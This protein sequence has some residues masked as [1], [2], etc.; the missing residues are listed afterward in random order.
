MKK[1]LTIGSP[2]L[3]AILLLGA[4]AC[5]PAAQ[6]D[7]PVQNPATQNPAA[8]PDTPVQG[9]A[10]QE[11]VAQPNTPAPPQPG[12]VETPAPIDGVE[13]VVSGDD[14]PQYT[15]EIVS[16][17]PSGCIKFGG[18]AVSRVDNTIHVTVNNLRPTSPAP[19]TMIYGTF[20]GQVDLGSGFIP[21]ESYTVVVN[22]KTTNTFIA[23]SPEGEKMTQTQSPIEKT[24]VMASQTEPFEYTLQVVSRL[25]MGSSCSKFDGYNVARPAA[26]IIDV[27]V[28]HL[29]VTDLRACTGD[30]PVVSTDIPL[31]ADF[32]AG[33]AYTVVVN[34]EIANSFTALQPEER[35]W[36]LKESPIQG[37]E[38]IILESFP[39]QYRMKVTYTL[40]KGSS[41]SRFNGY[42]VERPMA[43]TIEVSV[44]HFEVAEDNVPC[45]RD[46]PV[47][48]TNVSLG[49]NFESGEEYT[50]IINGQ[51]TK[52]FKA[53]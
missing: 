34:G 21:G 5:G 36:V 46:L 14:P 38:L 20:E 50:V 43:N 33:E 8:Q 44:T 42:D 40:P 17:L 45:T 29:E 15:L 9:P 41:C 16:G 10:T 7:T 4:L 13:L 22:G 27:T 3:M 35:D 39:P 11:P 24:R 37:A 19:C 32:T 23:Q 48:E 12:M 1:L 18:Y 51:V 25:P 26:G 49:I 52:T 6:P 30:L 2:F 28:T 47:G 31:G 53:Q